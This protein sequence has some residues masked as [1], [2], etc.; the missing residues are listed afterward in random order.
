[1]TGHGGRAA[2]CGERPGRAGLKSVL[3][4]LSSSVNLLLAV[5]ALRCGEWGGTWAA[6]PG[7]SCG[8]APALGVHS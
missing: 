8:G 1:M 6:H 2:R 7:L 4:A 3:L 5:R